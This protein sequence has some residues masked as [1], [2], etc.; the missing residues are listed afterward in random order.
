MSNRPKRSAAPWRAWAS[1]L[2][3]VLAASVGGYAL[4]ALAMTT[5]AAALPLVSPASNADGVLSA[6]LLSFAVYT[7]IAIW[8][9]SVRS[10][11]RAWLGLGLVALPCAAALA[12]IRWLG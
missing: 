4:T 8:V 12:L 10:A 3:R 5:L 7:G 1:V 6:T 2:S 11:T 9:F